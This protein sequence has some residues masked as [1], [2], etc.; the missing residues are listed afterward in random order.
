MQDDQAIFKSSKQTFLSH[1]KDGLW[2]KSSPHI[3]HERYKIRLFFMPARFRPVE[4][5]E[6][7]D[8]RRDFL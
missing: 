2:K 6:Y 7:S 1:I 8:E 3:L 5:I 4:G